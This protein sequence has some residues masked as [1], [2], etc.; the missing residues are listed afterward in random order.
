MNYEK[1]GLGLGVFSIGL[2]LVELLVAR[3]VATPP[4]PERAD[5]RK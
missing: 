4:T 3:R 5:W 1:F 2:G